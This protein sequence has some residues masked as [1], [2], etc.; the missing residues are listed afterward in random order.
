[1]SSNKEVRF[2][3]FKKSIHTD[4]SDFVTIYNEKTTNSAIG[5]KIL[6]EIDKIVNSL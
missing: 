3:Y 6:N 5:S 2:T 4:Y 1:L